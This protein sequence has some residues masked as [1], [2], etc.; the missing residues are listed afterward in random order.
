MSFPAVNRLASPITFWS[1]NI[2]L[3]IVTDQVHIL[4]IGFLP[5]FYA[6]Q[7]LKKL[8]YA[9]ESISRI[10]FFWIFIFRFQAPDSSLCCC[11]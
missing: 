5:E 11:G 10:L 2:V 7:T 6:I 8:V 1:S 4:E 9:I 3:V